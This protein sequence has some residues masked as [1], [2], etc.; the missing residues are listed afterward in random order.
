MSNIKENPNFGQNEEVY[1]DSTTFPTFS[2]HGVPIW[3]PHPARKTTMLG[4][5]QQQSHEANFTEI[6]F[7]GNES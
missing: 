3:G 7:L 5:M 2:G 1:I 6:K 4:I